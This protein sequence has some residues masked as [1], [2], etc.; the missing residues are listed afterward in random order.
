ME[1]IPDFTELLILRIMP[2][3]HL[4]AAIMGLSGI[5]YCRTN[6]PAYSKVYSESTW[7]VFLNNICEIQ[8]KVFVQILECKYVVF[9][10]KF[11]VIILGWHQIN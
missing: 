4:N 3:R 5:V 7:G 6:L 11:N 2:D 10:H 9:M 1:V 8:Y